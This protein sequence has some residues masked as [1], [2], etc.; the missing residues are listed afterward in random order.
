MKVNWDSIEE[1]SAH[2]PLPPGEY[3]VVVTDVSP[4]QAKSGDEYWRLEL[5]V[6]AGKHSGAI[7]TDS[8]FFTDKG[9]KRVKLVCSRLG[10]DTTGEKDFTTQD[11]I[12]KKA[13]VTVTIEE[14]EYQ[15]KK[16]KDNKIPFAGYEKYSVPLGDKTTDEV[17]KGD[18][19]PF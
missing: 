10:V 12:G 6:I 2:E 8:I 15:G 7:I 11:L 13:V 17:F 4:K 18:D 5:S 16:Y 3:T 9:W 19:L 14:R 1:G